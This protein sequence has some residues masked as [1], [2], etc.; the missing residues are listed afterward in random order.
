MGAPPLQQTSG[1]DTWKFDLCVVAMVTTVVVDVVVLVVDLVVGTTGASPLYMAHRGRSIIGMTRSAGNGHVRP[2]SSKRGNVTEDVSVVDDTVSVVVE[3]FVVELVVGVVAVAVGVD[4]VSVAVVEDMDI[5]DVSDT[6]TVV[7]EVV[8]MVDVE[9][10]AISTMV[11][12][13]EAA[14]AN[15]KNTTL[16][17]QPPPP[18]LRIAPERVARARI[19]R[20][21]QPTR[22]TREA[23]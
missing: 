4:V 8:D 18:M 16:C 7:F 1:T 13:T 20:L 19:S 3:V 23:A 14:T 17:P 2:P 10:A 5:V 21:P 22:R 9:L 12:A 15:R 6:D 11:A